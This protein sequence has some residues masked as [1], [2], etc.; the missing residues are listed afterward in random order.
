MVEGSDNEVESM[1]RRA[2]PALNELV[3]VYEPYEAVYR[4]AVVGGEVF[5]EATNTTTLPRA[6]VIASASAR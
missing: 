1:I 3:A 4:S 6:T 2:D 5:T